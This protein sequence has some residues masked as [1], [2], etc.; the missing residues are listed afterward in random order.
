[1]TILYDY[2]GGLFKAHEPPCLSLYQPTHRHHPENQQDLI[3]FRNLLKSLEELLRQKDPK[4]E[5][6]FLLDRF[7]ALADD[8][9]F[10]NHTLDGLA[11]LAAA[12]VFH[13]FR[14]Q[15]PVPE[16]VVVADSF[17]TKPLMRII[18]SADRYQ[19]LALSRGRVKLYEGNRY[20]L[21]EVELAE[22]VPGTLTEALGEQLTEPH[23]TAASYGSGGGG[24]GS[25]HGYGS[26]KDEVDAD[27]ERFFRAVD[28]AIYDHHSRPSGLPLMLAALPEHHTPFRRISRNPFL[29]AEGIEINPEA[30]SLEAL[31]DRAWKAIEPQYWERI[32]RLAEEF[33]AAKS[34]ELGSDE[35]EQV[36]NGA[37]TGRIATLLIQAERQIPGR[38]NAATGKIEFDSLD[39][40]GTDDLLDDIGEHVLK[41][42]GRVVVVPEERMPTRSGIA[43]IYKF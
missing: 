21:D 9:I 27:T 18:Q 28:R 37:A 15:R 39:H 14:L 13:V 26:R 8:H 3:R 20:A 35:L 10:W 33:A 36:A 34:K 25:W 11:V 31:R 29:M 19:I 30:L 32:T 22:E 4:R 23:L 42:G 38:W 16:L 12:D 41:M 5:W 43:A 17:H 1:M 6:Q 7:H 40:P 2:P 24:P